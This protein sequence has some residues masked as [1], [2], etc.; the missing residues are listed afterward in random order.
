MA[1]D[2]KFWLGGSGFALLLIVWSEVTTRNAGRFLDI[3]AGVMLG[4]L[5]FAWALGGHVSAFRWQLGAMGEQDT[6]AEIEKLGSEWHCEHDVV[7][8]HGNWDHIVVGPPGTFVLDSKLLHGRAVASGDALRAG[9]LT[10]SGLSSRRAAAVIKELMDKQLGQSA[11]WVQGVV[12]V[13]GD[14][15]QRQHEDDRVFYIAGDELVS[16]LSGLEP[17]LKQPQIDAR[18][19]ALRLVRKELQN[20]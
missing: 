10:Y 7:H 8:A 9:R 14:F 5:L 12:V 11:G 18:T 3:G 20:A 6:A 19:S 1:D 17:R 15:P 2:W 16:W 13:W 4:V